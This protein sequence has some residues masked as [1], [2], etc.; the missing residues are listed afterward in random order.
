VFREFPS[1]PNFIA[2]AGAGGGG[3]AQMISF[4]HDE[5]SPATTTE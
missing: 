5:V 2:C 1:R 3:F 4:N